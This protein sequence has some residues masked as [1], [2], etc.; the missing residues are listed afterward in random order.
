MDVL[1]S[2]TGGPCV[3][4]GRDLTTVHQG[5]GITD[6]DWRAFMSIITGTLQ[7]LQTEPVALQDFVRLFEDRFRPTVVVK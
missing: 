5:L 1:C 7:E 4:I 2:A 6:Q 3:Y